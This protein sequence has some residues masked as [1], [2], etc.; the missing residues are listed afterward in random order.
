[1]DNQADHFRTNGHPDQYQRHQHDH[2]RNGPRHRTPDSPQTQAL[3]QQPNPHHPLDRAT[4]APRSLSACHRSHSPQ[5]GQPSSL[6]QRTLHSPAH[7]HQRTLAYAII[8]LTT[9]RLQQ[10]HLL[11]DDQRAAIDQQLIALTQHNAH[12]ATT[13]AKTIDIWLQ[14]PQS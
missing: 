12:L 14:E 5:P 7:L 6:P 2:T 3:H 13:I 9:D 1:M 8:M 4:A 10:L 11:D